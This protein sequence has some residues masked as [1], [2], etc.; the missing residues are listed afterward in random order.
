MKNLL[1]GP[2]KN[3]IE[4]SQVSRFKYKARFKP[5]AHKSNT[6]KSY[7][8]VPEVP[9]TI[10]ADST[11]TKLVKASKVRDGSIRRFST[12]IYEINRK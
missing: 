2:S 10:G 12:K 4:T 6:A 11:W 9:A 1:Q 7:I 5:S 3:D 8:K